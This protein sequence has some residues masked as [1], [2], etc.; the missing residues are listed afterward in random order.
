MRGEFNIQFKQRKLPFYGSYVVFFMVFSQR[1][2][3]YKF[4]LFRLREPYNLLSG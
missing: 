4:C 1:L 3:L 2:T